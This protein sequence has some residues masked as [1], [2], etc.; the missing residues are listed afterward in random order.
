MHFRRKIRQIHAG[1]DGRQHGKNRKHKK[2][3]RRQNAHLYR[4]S[5]VGNG[6][7]TLDKRPCA[8]V[9]DEDDK[10]VSREEVERAAMSAK[11]REML[12]DGAVERTQ[13]AYSIER[14]RKNRQRNHHED[15]TLDD[16]RHK[17]APYSAHNGIDEN[18]CRAK[19]DSRRKRNTE[20]LRCYYAKRV[21]AHGIVDDAE[22]DA[23]PG[24][25]LAHA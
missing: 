14:E 16:V 5:L 9:L 15:G 10:I 20:E 11:E 12:R 4:I 3:R 21:Q 8:I 1:G 18:N 17:Y 22:R 25:H 2:Y 6:R 13:S 23:A 7:K 24:K 19:G